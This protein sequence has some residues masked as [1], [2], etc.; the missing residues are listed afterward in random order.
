MI[1]DK[2]EKQHAAE[3]A[4]LSALQKTPPLSQGGGS[5]DQLGKIAA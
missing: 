5:V 3:Q 4:A 1:R 2:K